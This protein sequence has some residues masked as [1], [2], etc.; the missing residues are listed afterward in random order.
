MKNELKKG[1]NCIGQIV[2]DCDNNQ[3]EIVDFFVENGKKSKV[4]IKYTDGTEQVREKYAV[5]QGAFKKPYLDTIEKDLQSGNWRYIPSFNQR[6]IISKTGE[7]KSAQGV[8]K[9]KILSPSVDK[10][11]YLMIVIAP[12]V[13]RSNRKLCRIHRLVAS[14]F[15][16]PIEDGEEVNHIDGNKQNN[17][18]SNLEIISREDNNKKYLDLKDLGLSQ[19]EINEIEKYCL[20]NDITF[21]KYILQKIKGEI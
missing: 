10:G 6:Y 16:R 5:Q 12:T 21:K 20:K 11:G 17:A 1:K 7:I 14:T 18:I 4:I 2:F 3:G 19:T 15:I 9:G 13:G 8:N